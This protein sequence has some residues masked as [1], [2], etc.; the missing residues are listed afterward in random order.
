MGRLVN[1]ISQ[2]EF[3]KLPKWQQFIGNYPVVVYVPMVAIFVT[4]I[5]LGCLGVIK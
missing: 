5:V 1:P 3:E 4:L 2:E